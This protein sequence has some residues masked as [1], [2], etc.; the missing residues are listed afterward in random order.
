[1]NKLF[2]L[3]RLV[4]YK[5]FELQKEEDLSPN[6]KDK[7][8]I[9]IP[10]TDKDL[11][12]LPLCLRGVLDN[13]SNVIGDIYLVAPESE[14]IIIFAE[15]YGIKYVNEKKVLGYDKSSINF[16][17]KSGTDRSG[18]IFQQL[19]KLSGSI[20]IN[21]YYL[22]IDADHI[23]IHPHIFLTD[24]NRFVFY[25]SPEFHFQY[26]INIYRLFGKFPINLFSY[27]SHKMIFDKEILSNYRKI[28]EKG[29]LKWDQAILNS[30]NKDDAS[31][32]SEYESYAS[33]VDSNQKKGLPW[34][35]K[36]LRRNEFCSDYNILK[37]KYSKYMSLTYPA[38]LI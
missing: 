22:V 18:W 19:L 4:L 35:Q 21:R 9:I 38:Y 34:R 1:M 32:F 23:L 7:V 17:S 16:I 11:K 25:Q 33:F 27:I 3:I 30:L 20:G 13:M 37:K 28:L 31:P 2:Y 15:S 10:V 12:I 29:G 26:Y 24:D 6:L 8:D 36:S 5:I 14:K